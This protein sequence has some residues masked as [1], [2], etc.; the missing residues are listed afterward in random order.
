[1]VFSHFDNIVK[2]VIINIVKLCTLYCSLF[3][4]GDAFNIYFGK[5]NEIYCKCKIRL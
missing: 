2:F 4:K 5:K 3:I 1:M